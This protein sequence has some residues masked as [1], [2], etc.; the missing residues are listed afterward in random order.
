VRLAFVLYS[1]DDVEARTVC[2]RL[3][4]Q[5]N[6]LWVLLYRARMGLRE[7]LEKNWIEGK[8]GK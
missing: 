1:I 3:G 4:V 8:R 6:H 7:C 5:E 2:E